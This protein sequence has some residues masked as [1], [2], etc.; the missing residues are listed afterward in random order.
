M[1]DVI[2]KPKTVERYPKRILKK[3]KD[4]I[5]VMGSYEGFDEV[6]VRSQKE[7]CDEQI[8]GSTRGRELVD[9]ETLEI[10]L[11]QFRINIF[12]EN[13]EGN[14][15][16]LGQIVELLTHEIAH[17]VFR[18]HTD[19]HR[20]LKYILLKILYPSVNF[21]IFKKFELWYGHGHDRRKEL[22]D[23]DIMPMIDKL[24]YVEEN[25]YGYSGK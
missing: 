23:S 20:N 11:T 12:T 16:I 2:F 8:K 22:Y 4:W 5:K 6:I 10:K 1:V 9:G 13:K 19:S 18:G 14:K 24:S 25:K 7:V 17:M 21:E 15:K 3:A